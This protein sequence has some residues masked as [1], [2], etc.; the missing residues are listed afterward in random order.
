MADRDI[1][2]IFDESLVEALLELLVAYGLDA[3][4]GALEPAMMQ[5]SMLAAAISFYGSGLRGSL[6]VMAPRAAI[7]ATQPVSWTE[8][9]L[10]DWIGELGNQALGCIRRKLLSRGLHAVMSFPAVLGAIRLDA[11]QIDDR[12]TKA[13]AFVTQVGVFF[14][15]LDVV[16]LNPDGVQWGE[17]SEE[18]DNDGQIF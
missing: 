14:V 4:I 12:Y 15:C 6:L 8:V 16:C 2:A 5:Q 9:R 7:A 11:R 18:L 10:R 1:P 3:R 13:H 17:P